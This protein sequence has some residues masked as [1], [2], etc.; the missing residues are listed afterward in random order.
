MK[1]KRCLMRTPSNSMRLRL[2]WLPGRRIGGTRM[3]LRACRCGGTPHRRS[4]GERGSGGARTGGES[5]TSQ[6]KKGFLVAMTH[7]GRLRR[8]PRRDKSQTEKREKNDFTIFNF[9]P[10]PSSKSVLEKKSILRKK[11]PFIYLP[12][13]FSRGLFL[14]LRWPELFKNCCFS[15]MN[16]LTM[17]T[18]KLKRVS[19]YGKFIA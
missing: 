16:G 11:P 1:L 14:P 15:I 10:S 2:N 4:E 17:E 6:E 7:G 8:R 5:K 13:I 19:K 3:A 12:L 9:A 18:A